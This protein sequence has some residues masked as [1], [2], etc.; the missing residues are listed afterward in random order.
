MGVY[1]NPGN[2]QFYKAVS[3][4]IYVDKTMMIRYTNECLNTE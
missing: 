4:K 1:F 3:S 2:G